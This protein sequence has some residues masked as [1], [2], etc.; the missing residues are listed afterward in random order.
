[1]T[2]STTKILNFYVKWF[3]MTRWVWFSCFFTLKVQKKK[4]RSKLEMIFGVGLI[5]GYDA[6]FFFCIFGVHELI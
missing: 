1:V 4:N 3:H 6:L 5:L 2:I